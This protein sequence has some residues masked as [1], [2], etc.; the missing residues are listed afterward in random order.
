MLISFC[1]ESIFIAFWIMMLGGK[2]MGGKGAMSFGKSRA[3]VANPDTKKVKFEDVAGDN[4]IDAQIG[5]TAL[6]VCVYDASL[7]QP[8]THQH[9]GKQRS[10]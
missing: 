1:S 3:K 8:G 2:D 9:H 7:F 4:H 5:Q 10:L 6:S